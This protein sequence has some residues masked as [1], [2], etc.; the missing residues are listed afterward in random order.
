MERENSVKYEKEKLRKIIKKKLKE[1]S[2]VYIKEADRKIS[3][4]VL[5]LKA[6]KKAKTVFCFISTEDEISTYNIVERILKDGKKLIVPKCREGEKGIMDAFEI[7]SLKDL[8]PG[9]YKIMEPV[10]GTRKAEP[11]EADFAVIPCISC[12]KTGGR[13]G[14]GGGYY[15]RYLENTDFPCA[16]IC[17]EKLVWEKVPED[18][19][20][21]KMDY[22]VTENGVTEIKKV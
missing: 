8:E 1:L 11:R 7:L 22:V 17:R 14:H 20:D 9:K 13:L 12:D 16:V 5:N 3:D 6:Y 15:D 4:N 21:R 2:P 19:H 18:I 10:R